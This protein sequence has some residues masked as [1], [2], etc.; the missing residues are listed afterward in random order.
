MSHAAGVSFRDCT[1]TWGPNPPDYFQH[2]L[3]A[4]ACPGLAADGISGEAAHP[5]MAAKSIQ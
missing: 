2:A 5:G 1:V 4:L 3:D